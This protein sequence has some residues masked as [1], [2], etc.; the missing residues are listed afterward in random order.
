MIHPGVPAPNLAPL[1]GKDTLKRRGD[2]AYR[3]FATRSL[4]NRCT[5]PSMPFE[6]TV[7]PYR[8]CSMGC[9][10]CYAT[11]THEYLGSSVAED[12]HASIYVKRDDPQE[13][14]RRLA[15]AV[16]RG[17]RIALGTATDPYQPGEAEE[18]VTR[19]FLEQVA[20]QRGVRLGIITKG[21]VIL[22]D[23]ELLQRIQE[24]STLSI[25]VSLISLDAGLLRRL[26]PWA[27]PPEVRLEVLRRLA[28]A[29]LDVGISV[30]PVLPALTDRETDLDQLLGRAAEAGVRRLSSTLLFLRSPTREKYFRWIEA[31]F[32]RYLEAYRRAYAKSAYLSGPYRTRLR[33]ILDRLRAKHRFERDVPGRGA[34]ARFAGPARQLALW[35][36][37]TI[38]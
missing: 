36:T 38:A 26:E 33:A 9:R 17:E 16:R 27:P 24:R 15:R 34:T 10:Y 20:Q 12:F 13:T 14:S 8:G 28:A 18:G 19:R 23:V 1:L 3:A 6:W 2:V 5:S 29:G 11:Y 37:A 32:P 7:N 22:R 21:A 4:L 35:D 31:E 30:S 25:H